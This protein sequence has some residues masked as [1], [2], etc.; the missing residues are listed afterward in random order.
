MPDQ[1]QLPVP[2]AP[3]DGA[4]FDDHGATIDDLRAKIARIEDDDR[5]A[6]DYIDRVVLIGGTAAILSSITFLKDIA[7]APTL[8]SLFLLRLSWSALLLGAALAFASFFAAR[9]AARAYRR[10]LEA[11]LISGNATITAEDYAPVRFPNFLTRT[12]TRAG[13]ASF[14][15]GILLLLFFA[16]DNLPAEGTVASQSRSDSA[17]INLVDRLQST[18]RKGRCVV[19]LGYDYDLP[20]PS[21]V[22]SDSS[23][24]KQPARQRR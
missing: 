18:C 19:V 20:N 14:L 5:K 16:F 7:A 6:A 8:R 17:F 11:K 23:S 22:R 12:F 15:T 21:R 2:S 3:P 4:T 9:A 10:V 24:L 1:E 13:V